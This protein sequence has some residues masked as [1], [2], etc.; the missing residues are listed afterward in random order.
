M[1][2]MQRLRASA[3]RCA[4]VGMETAAAAAFASERLQLFS[5]EVQARAWRRGLVTQGSMWCRRRTKQKCGQASH[6]GGGR[7]ARLAVGGGGPAVLAGGDG[8][9]TID[10]CH[11]PQ[12]RE[13]SSGRLEQEHARG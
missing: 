10:F 13:R 4:G 12:G 7:G 2:G 9:E 11:R 3:D 6:G 1:R 8:E 5:Q